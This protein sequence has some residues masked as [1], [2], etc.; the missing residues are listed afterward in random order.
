MAIQVLDS[1][2]IDKIAAGEVVERPASV[3]KELVENAIDA[4]ADTITVEAKSGG[5]AFLR[6]TDNGCGVEESQVRTAFCRHATSKISCAE[7]LTQI[8]S[9][10]FR[11]EALSSIAAV[12]QVE[13]ITKPKN[14]LTGTRIVLEGGVEKEFAQV[15]APDGTT[16]IMRNLFYNTPVRQKFLKTPSTEGG[17]ILELIE[18]LALSRPDISFKLIL[19]NKERIHTMGN[20]EL[21]GVLYNLYGRETVQ[22]VLPIAYEE[23]GVRVD[24][25]LGKSGFVRAN[26]N[27]ELFCINGRFIKCPALSKAVEEGYKEYLMQHKFPFFVLHIQMPPEWVDVNVHP[28][29]MEVRFSDAMGLCEDLTRA[30]RKALQS[31]E[32][33]PQSTLEEPKAEFKAEPKA[34]PKAERKIEPR[35]E[36]KIEAKI[37]SNIEPVVQQVISAAKEMPAAREVEQEVQKPESQSIPKQA[38][39]TFTKSQRSPESFETKRAEAYRVME[40]ARYQEEVPTQ[41]NL[42]EEKILSQ[43]NRSRYRLIGQVF[44]TYWLLQFEDQLMIM[45]QHAAHE[46]V[47]YERLMKQYREK[48]IVSQRLMPPIILSLSG[49]EES[50]LQNHLEVFSQ[51][52]FEVEDFGGNEYTLRSVPVDLYGCGEKE[53]FLEVLDQLGSDSVGGLRVV[54]EKIA[55]MSCKAAVKGNNRLSH[56]EA[57]KLIDELLTL[58][59]PYNC[60]HGRPTIIKIS[61][62]EMEKKFKRIL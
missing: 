28:T 37:E 45:D 61:K 53:M 23:N 34:E 7:D 17:Y 31:T 5:I 62:S 6:V 48:Q 35:V 49:R 43:E 60:P 25:Y 18:H 2:T 54:E 26:R 11:G 33:I 32:M 58:E 21:R 22:N 44:D 20:G 10:G 3:V 57:E 56:Q 52:G 14:S 40:E 51:M 24:G 12:S 55:S 9:L 1:A 50:I 47:K 38:V 16:F 19:D 36:P 42:F 8:L 15:G 27:Y 30:V 41:L 39:S 59:N 46:K 29:K 4:G 13:M